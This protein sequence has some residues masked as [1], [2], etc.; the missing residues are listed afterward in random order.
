MDVNHR[1]SRPLF[2][3]KIAVTILNE[4]VNSAVLMIL[5]ILANEYQP[6]DKHSKFLK[7]RP[8]AGSLLQGT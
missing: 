3:A 5:S 4:R 6:K 8:G 1:I 7:V 2:H